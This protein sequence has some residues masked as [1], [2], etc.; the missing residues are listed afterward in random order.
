MVK[1]VNSCIQENSGH[2]QHLLWTV[3]Q[4][5][6]CCSIK[7]WDFVCVLKWTL[8]II[9]IFRTLNQ[10]SQAIISRNI[11]WAELQH[12]WCRVLGCWLTAWSRRWEWDYV[13]E[14]RP[15]TGLLFISQVIHEHG[16]PWRDDDAGWGKLLIIWQSYWNKAEEWKK[17]V[18]ILPCKH[19][20]HIYKWFLHAVKSYDTGPP[21]LLPIRRNVCCVFLSQLKIQRLGRVWTRD[22]WVQWQAL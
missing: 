16:E 3:F 22:P 11:S 10:V 4:V 17:A 2:F 9:I 12:I 14:L 1:W 18:R 19:F 6:L 20:V 13:S 8:C 5:L 21:A 7:K 15:P